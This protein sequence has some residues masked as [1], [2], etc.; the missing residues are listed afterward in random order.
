MTPLRPNATYVTS[1]RAL[2]KWAGERVKLSPLED[3]TIEARFRFDGTTC[4][5][6]GRPL[7]FEYRVLLGTAEE[8][9]R[10]VSAE[11]G[12][13]EEEDGYRHMCAY[14]SDAEGLM[15]AIATP[16]PVV[17]QP[18]DAV[19]DWSRASAPSGCYCT[20]SSREHKWGLA[21]EAIHYALARSAAAAAT[22]ART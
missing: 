18:L 3:G 2:Q 21:L 5:N 15:K 10:I 17:G 12:P 16:P 20:A 9:H 13:I 4:S 22:S 7:A 8:G 1:V 6:M 19:L 14:I 11:C